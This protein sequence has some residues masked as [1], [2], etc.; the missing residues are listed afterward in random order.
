MIGY[1]YRYPHPLIKGEWLYVG[2]GRDRDKRHRAGTTSFGRRFR[3]AFP[4]IELSKPVRWT[5]NVDSHAELNDEEKI[6]MFLYKTWYGYS[7]GMNLTF[8]G[9]INYKIIGHLGGSIGG[10]IGGPISGRKNV[11]NGHLA[12]I[13]KLAKTKEAQREAGRVQG[14]KNV[15]SGHLA[16]ARTF[17]GQ[18]KGKRRK[19]PKS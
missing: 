18:A 11:T 6:A 12:C 13:R 8:P 1:L 14:R 2:Q 16:K 19:T 17:I 4:G 5:V 10:L 9:A 7:G 15:E 3:K